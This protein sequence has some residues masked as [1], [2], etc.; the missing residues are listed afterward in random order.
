MDQPSKTQ[1]DHRFTTRM[2]TGLA[3]KKWSP[4]GEDA[5]LLFCLF[6]DRV[7]HPDSHSP[8]AIYR[9]NLLHPIFGHY[10]MKNFK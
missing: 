2:A 9:H 3:Q 5:G 7:F 1:F 6:M 10:E 8:A 4:D